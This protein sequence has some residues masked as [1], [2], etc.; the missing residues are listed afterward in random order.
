MHRLPPLVI[1]HLAPHTLRYIPKADVRALQIH[2]QQLE[3]IPY[4]DSLSTKLRYS[5][6]LV[7]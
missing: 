2:R 6:S 4:G 5:H 7:N 1:F 3:A